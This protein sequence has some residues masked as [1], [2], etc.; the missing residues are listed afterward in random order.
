MIGHEQDI[1]RLK[2]L[3]GVSRIGA[4]I[5]LAELGGDVSD[6]RATKALCSWAGLSP[7]NNESAGKRRSGKT[8]QGNSRLK[9]VF[10][11]AGWAAAKTKIYYFKQKWE[12]IHLRL[13][14]KK[15]IVAIGN[16]ILH[17]IYSPL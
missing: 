17:V 7:D 8:K 11:E 14:F 4:M 2:I 13:G 9:R 10:C 12:S 5:I 16:K 15:A 3:P 6:F 1:M